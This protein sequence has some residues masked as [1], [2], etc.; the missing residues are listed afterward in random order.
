MNTN[1]PFLK[2]V[3]NMNAKALENFFVQIG[4]TK[5]SETTYK[6]QKVESMESKSVKAG[7]L[8]AIQEATRL[9]IQRLAELK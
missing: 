7:N 5:T 4:F 8:R 9:L 6:F 1:S 2:Q 3:I